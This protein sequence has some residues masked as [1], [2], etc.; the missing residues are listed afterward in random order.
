MSSNKSQ[1]RLV[2]SV[3]CCEGGFKGVEQIPSRGEHTVDVDIALK[4]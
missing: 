2:V 1:I 4:E 3:P